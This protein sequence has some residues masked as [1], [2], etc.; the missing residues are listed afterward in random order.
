MKNQKKNKYWYFTEITECVLCGK[1]TIVKYRVYDKPRPDDRG[2]RM[3]Y[4]QDV[5]AIH[6][7]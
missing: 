3:V 5:C 7:I 4:K 6:F 1:E 2:D